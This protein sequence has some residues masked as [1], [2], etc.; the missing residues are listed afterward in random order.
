MQMGVH[1][2][3]QFQEHTTT[4]GTLESVNSRK[5]LLRKAVD[6]RGSLFKMYMMKGKIR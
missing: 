2:Q 6:K 1:R 5:S 3:P 4:L